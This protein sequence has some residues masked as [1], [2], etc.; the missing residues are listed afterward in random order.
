[1][2]VLLIACNLNMCYWANHLPPLN[3]NILFYLHLFIF[4]YFLA[5][6][7]GMWDLSLLTRDGTRIP[8]IGSAESQP[9]DHQGSPLASISLF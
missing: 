7:C 8:C 3:F 5:A 4:F 9:L 6:L 1:M 2:Y